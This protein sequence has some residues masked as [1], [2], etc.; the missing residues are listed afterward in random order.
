MSLREHSIYDCILNNARN[1][2][3]EIALVSGDLRLTYGEVPFH[4]NSL[5]RGLL[6][7]G[8][9]K[10]DRI[11]V[12][13]NNCAEYALLLAACTRIGVITVC[14]NT[15]TS[16]EEMHKMLEQAEPKALIFQKS[17]EQQADQLRDLHIHR[18]LYSI[19][20]ASVLSSSFDQ[21]LD[22]DPSPLTEPQPAVDDGWLIIPTAAVDGIPKG[23]L[24]SQ[25]NV[26]AS[27]DVHLHHFGREAIK[28]HLVALPIYHVMGLTSAWATFI[29][30]G[31]NVLL[32]QFD[33]KLAVE[34]ID[35]EKLT[36]FGA[37]PP[38]LE[39]V[40][41]A[42]KESG[43]GL[44]SL[45]LVYGLEGAE[46]IQRLQ[47]K[48]GAEFWTVFGQAETTAFVTASPASERPGA[49]GR[50][51][52]INTVEVVNDANEILSPGEEGE[53]VVRGENVFLEYWNMPEATAHTL[54]N[55]W[56]HTGDIGRFDE[57]GYLWYVKRKAEK[58]L[59]K[60]GGENVYPG[61]VETVLL[62]HAEINDCSVIGVPDKTWGEAVKAICVLTPG[63]NLSV[64]EVRDFVGAQI[65]GFKKPRQVIFV[66]ELPYE[67]N[68]IDREA[69]K[70]KWGE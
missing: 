7:T 3:D 19:D 8:F 51:S 24:L 13:L 37:F 46:N 66:D 15:R 48:T 34:L 53:I 17:Y 23:A 30:G 27:A 65:A 40:L 28:G 68:Q 69:V 36:Y 70:E 47:E 56:H 2:S 42:A 6:N 32:K 21:L 25:R 12:L 43:S 16:A 45:K 26:F 44:E 5:A 64:E 41:D 35:T 11:A 58:E 18:Q 57:G 39:R 55:G 14:L 62:K 61:E 60:S 63:S 49:S 54:R 38:V 67:N 22:E 29:S 33:E 52:L 20:D 4:V 59:I 9:E 10:G 31:K 50:A 1:F